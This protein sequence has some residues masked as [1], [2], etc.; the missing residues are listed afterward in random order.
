[1]NGL[2]SRVMF[3]QLIIIGSLLLNY[4]CFKSISSLAEVIQNACINYL[5]CKILCVFCHSVLLTLNIINLL[6]IYLFQIITIFTGNSNAI[7]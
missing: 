2:V 4:L 7:A 3:E 1:M 6:I 5:F